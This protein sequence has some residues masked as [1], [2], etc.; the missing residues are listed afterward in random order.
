MAPFFG[1]SHSLLWKMV[2]LES[3]RVDLA[4]Q[5]G[6][7]P[8]LCSFIRGFPFLGTGFPF[9]CGAVLSHDGVPPPKSSIS[10]WDC[11][12]NKPSILGYPPKC[13]VYNGKSHWNGLFYLQSSSILVG[14]SIRNHL[15]CGI[16]ICGNPQMSRLFGIGFTSPQQIYLMDIISPRRQ[17]LL[18]IGYY[19]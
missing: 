6:D 10:R 15:F 12:W 5:N 13:L 9:K 19:Y 17:K 1:N 8:R 16:P 7:F 14:F 3:F 4:I 11:P 2:H 18:L